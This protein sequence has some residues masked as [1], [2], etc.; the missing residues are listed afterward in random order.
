VLHQR[1]AVVLWLRSKADDWWAADAIENGEHVKN[2]PEK[3]T[4]CTCGPVGQGQWLQVSVADVCAQV[5]KI[6]V[7]KCSCGAPVN[8]GENDVPSE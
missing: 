8:L 7:S 3:G 2:P 4:L 1:G 5:G 6:N